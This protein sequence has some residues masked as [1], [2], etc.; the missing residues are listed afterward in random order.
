MYT[1][2]T[3]QEV[4]KQ[5]EVYG[6]NKLP[7]SN[8]VSLFKLLLSQFKSPL[9]ILLL[10]TALISFVF[11]EGSDAI[12]ITIVLV[13]NISIGLSQEY[14]AQKT[15]QA[16]KNM[17]EPTTTVVR[18]NSRKRI[19]THEIVPG[20]IVVLGAGDII[21][22]DGKILE[23]NYL[24]IK[25]AILTGESE[26]IPKDPKKDNLVFMGT[27]VL[28]GSGIFKV[29]K[30]ALETKFGKIGEELIK[31]ND[32]ETPLQ[33]SL[34]DFSKKLSILVI[35][36]AITIF[37]IGLLYG[38]PPTEMFR[39]AIIL[40]IAI[41]PE[42][43]PVVV[44]VILARGMNRILKKK[45]LVKNLL[46]VETLGATTVICVDKTGTLTTGNMQIV[47]EIMVEKDR[48]YEAFIIN[49]DQRTNIEI[50]MWEYIKKT[51]FNIKGFVKNYKKEFFES[52]SSESKYALTI[53]SC[54]K[55]KIAYLTGAPDIILKYIGDSDA[56]KDK[57]MSDISFLASQGYR[58][59]ASAYKIDSDTENLKKKT[60]Y[61]WSGL[62]AIYDPLR[63]EAKES[64][65][66]AQQ[67]GISVKILTGDYIK[68]AEKIAYNLNL[69]LKRDEMLEG[70]ELDKMTSKQ[71]S[72]IIDKIRLF[73]RIT[74]QHKLKIIE[75][76]QS[77]GEVV[78]MTGDGVNDVLALKKAD[79]GIAMGN[80]AEVTKEAA[81]LILLNNNFSTI[82]HTI[83]EGRLVFKNIRKVIGYILSNSFAEITLIF[84]TF[85]L[86]LPTPLTVAQILWIHLICDGPP[87]LAL[88]FD[89]DTKGLLQDK[90]HNS[91]KEFI[92]DKKTRVL[93]LFVS[94][95]VAIITLIVYSHF[96]L[97][98]G[99]TQ[100]G[101]TISF[102]I[103]SI[104]SLSYLFSYKELEVPVY[105]IKG[106]FKNKIIIFSIIYGLILTFMAIYI[107]PIRGALGNSVLELNHWIIIIL[108][109]LIIVIGVEVIKLMKKKY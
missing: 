79:I 44:T 73:A 15:L 94:I 53:C 25:E 67:G 88:G 66:L 75:A 92:L 59:I 102:A 43:L 41:I 93:I 11:N 60:G 50:A 35:I 105:R 107:E 47:D 1:G 28:K 80:S 52:F 101:Q 16:L 98:V 4:A 5:R 8:E 13:L 65:N 32:S 30:I 63:P 46:S 85:L 42:G 14:K 49:N 18:N 62:L 68:T 27:S 36:L 72:K 55:E 76:L 84:A 87:D 17:L 12:L 23:A 38:N 57:I 24:L 108:V 109:A 78:A 90:P 31:I 83:E 70:K 37:I 91:K 82:I 9:I 34:S 51:G 96:V 86:R 103:L 54:P 29:E 106:I 74:P 77:K 48:S 26:A 33:K 104:I 10:I 58:L 71:L 21:P 99:D 2:L 95:T 7:S 19:F 100:L 3:T 45:G 61:I 22:A 56:T 89:T 97:R 39:Y 20:D 6:E 69:D 81:D 40:A 64:L